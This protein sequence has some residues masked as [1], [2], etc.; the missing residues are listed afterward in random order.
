V[1]ALRWRRV[2]G[3]G[4]T[5]GLG[6][7][8]A[9]RA[10]PAAP[11]S[12]RYSL[13]SALAVLVFLLAAGIAVLVRDAPKPSDVPPIP[14][15]VIPNPQLQSV[16]SFD[17]VPQMWGMADA[18]TWR[19]LN[20][21]LFQLDAGKTFSTDLEWYTQ[22]DGP[23]LIMVERGE[24]TLQPSGPALFYSAEDR[25]HAPREIAAG[26]TIF[27][28]PYDGIAYAAKEPAS[29]SNFGSEPAMALLGDM[30]HLSSESDAGPIDIRNL[31]SQSDYG[32]APL[33]TAGASIS[34][35]HL[36][37]APYDSFVFEPGADWTYLTAFDQFRMAGAQMADGAVDGLSADVDIHWLYN[38]VQLTY[39]S[40]GPH[41]IF[42]LGDAPFDIYFLVLEPYPLQA[43]TT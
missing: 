2:N 28:G 35:Q 32:I 34:I 41:T 15:E 11:G 30:G 37:L 38:S 43:A 8:H 5:D 26:Q 9:P 36:R 24:L 31:D 7:A 27:L 4:I 20:F 14:A 6:V 33:P 19:Y 3:A 17:F 23:I 22:V 25:D 13:A 29:G 18:T 10:R 42:N 12:R 1:N 39:P 40:P 16:V 21:N